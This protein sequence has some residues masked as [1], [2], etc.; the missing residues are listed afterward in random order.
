MSQL[1]LWTWGSLADR[2]QLV[3]VYRTYTCV[4][5]RA[6]AF[7][8]MLNTVLLQ[9]CVMTEAPEVGQGMFQRDFAGLSS[10]LLSQCLVRPII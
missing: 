4:C 3:S 8:V 10:S 9:L 7:L 6:C 5:Q 1:F 2:Q